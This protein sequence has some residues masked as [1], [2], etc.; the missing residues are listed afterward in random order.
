VAN[1][2]HLVDICHVV[3]TDHFY[4]YRPLVLFSPTV[5]RCDVTQ[6]TIVYSSENFYCEHKCLPNKPVVETLRQV[7]AWLLLQCRITG[8]FVRRAYRGDVAYEKPA[9]YPL[10]IFMDIYRN[11]FCIPFFRACVFHL[12]LSV[13]HTKC[14][15]YRGVQRYRC[16]P[17]ILIRIC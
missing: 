4:V 10:H 6:I 5:S 13:W 14:P 2:C 7:F 17:G 16:L 8:A 12:V 9:D 11:K 15:I 3:G 1:I